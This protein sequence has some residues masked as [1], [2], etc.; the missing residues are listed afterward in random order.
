VGIQAVEEKRQGVE[1]Q[2][3]LRRSIR[4]AS[5][6]RLRVAVAGSGTARHYVLHF[7][8]PVFRVE[9]VLAL[10]VCGVPFHD[11]GCLGQRS[12]VFSGEVSQGNGTAVKAGGGNQRAGNKLEF[13]SSQI[14]GCGGQRTGNGEV[15]SSPYFLVDVHDASNA[16]DKAG[17][18]A[19]GINPADTKVEGAVQDDVTAF[20]VHL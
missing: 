3:R 5:P 10:I 4:E 7:D 11:A 12:A 17:A 6:S 15:R 16:E 8:V 2:A 13:S 9:I 14:R 18:V 1:G 19:A 20:K